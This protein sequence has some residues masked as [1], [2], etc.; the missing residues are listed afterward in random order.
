[1]RDAAALDWKNR[2]ER[3]I[4]KMRVQ[5]RLRR[6]ATS[7][8]LPLA[9]AAVAAGIFIADILTPPDVVVSGLYVVVVL[10]ASRFCRPSGVVLV[11]AGCIGLVL[12][13]YFFSAETA[14][15]A[16][17]RIPA[18]GAA[19][20]LA[21]QSLSAEA[22][23]REQA[24]LLDLT[25]DT[26]IARRFDDDVIT[27]W[28]RG[29]EEMYGWHRAEAVGRVGYELAKTTFPMPLDQ[30]K[31]ELL[32]VGR[33]E[34]EL[35]NHKRDGTPV[36]VTSRW[37]LQ[38]DRRGRPAVILVTSN[39]IT[40]RKRAEEALRESEE[41]WRRL[42]ET[43]AAGMALEGLDGVFTAANPALQRML[44]RAEEEI[45]GHNVLELNHEDER[46]ATADAL[47][48]FRSGSLTERQVEKKYL[49]KD[50]SLVWLNITTTLVPATETAAPFLQAV[51]VDVTRRVQ[52]EAA[53]RASDE[54]WRAIF[55]SAA[56]GI[57]TGGLDG[58]VLSMNPTFQ[59]MLGYTGDEFRNLTVFEFT[60]E[61][62]RAET[63]RFFSGIV[64]GQQT[65]YR[66][67]KRYQRKDG[68]TVWADVSASMVPAT[69]TTPAFLAVMA[70]ETTD[71][72]RAEAALRA[73]EERWRR[74]FETSA[75]GMA[76]ARLDGVFTAANP[77]LQRMLDRTEGEIVGRTA[78]EITHED[79]RPETANVVAKFRRGLL[80]E[81]H[82]EKRY[83]KRDGSPVWL[84][85]T[86]TLVPA[87]ETADPFLQAIY[88]NITD[89]KRA[90][91][92]LQQAQAD[93]ARLNRVMLL[94]EMT[95]SI[96]HEI[97]Q[98]IAAVITN[99]NA[100]LRWLGARQ[101]DLDEVQ[102]AL[103]RIVRDGT[104]AG[105]VI[106]RI[107]ALVKKVPPR[108][109]RLDIN[110]AI[111]E[112]TALTETEIQ[113]NGVRLQS[114]LADGLPLVS[115]DRVQLQQVMINLIVNAIEAMSGVSGRPREL[116]IVSGADD[117]SDMLVEVRDT[118]PGLDPEQRD[119]LFQSFYT[120]KPDGIGM[121]LA[122][123]RSIAEA[124]GGRLSV[125]PNKPCGAVFRLTLPVGNGLSGS[126]ERSCR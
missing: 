58:G 2:K 9:T 64:T 98:P 10:M 83:L 20:F 125:S 41:R 29:A 107:R 65:G 43:S 28:N 88:I 31:A 40:E 97:N 44:G 34:G 95:A 85:M 49:K 57:A 79:E 76:T 15:N 68:A 126:P 81:S 82:V 47:A 78:M 59:R 38:W 21:L 77:A 53:L 33:W 120:T 71:R 84:N 18:I 7:A 51:Y 93:L 37:T 110:E 112:V 101:P 56:V 3:A 25:H 54:R 19:T 11:A 12:A 42:F 99:A 48:K 96:A 36:L 119:R 105:E 100:G 14:I 52:S 106:G 103:G 6:R 67:E 50:G 27:Y 4:A 123:S 113:R 80:Q 102:Q 26:I 122:I 17:I 104:R 22:R 32:R 55:E 86:T 8:L 116:T 115:A 69:D 89:R 62:D 124:H 111:R 118:G 74:I 70:V 60:H 73:S 5:S 114:R 94:G 117:A 109:D 39:D 108:R 61:E 63:R 23:L 45:V 16:A 90:E 75:A 72:K 1:M 91:E 121:G 87:T 35:V 92:A 46:A 24:G 13:A 30:I 66:L